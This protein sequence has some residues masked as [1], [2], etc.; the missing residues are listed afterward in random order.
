MEYQNAQEDTWLAD[1]ANI[2]ASLL[3]LGSYIAIT[4][5]IEEFISTSRYIVAAPKGYGKTLLIKYKRIKNREFARDGE[6]VEIPSNSEIDYLD[7]SISFDFKFQDFLS[8]QSEWENLWQ[9]AIGL[10]IIINYAIKRKDIEFIEEFNES[11]CADNRLT[12]LTTLSKKVAK[13]IS[14][15]QQIPIYLKTQTNPS[16]ILSMILAS[17]LSDVRS[18]ISISLDAIHNWCLAIDLPTFVYIDQIDQGVREFP[19]EI[20]KNAQNGL[21]GAAFKIHNPNSHI[22]IYASIRSE[23]WEACASEMYAQYKDHVCTLEYDQDDLK[24]IF[25]H[26]VRTYE[27]ARDSAKNEQFKTNPIQGFIGLEQVRNLWSKENEDVFQYMLRHSLQRPR[28]LILIGGGIHSLYK[29]NK[30][31]EIAFCELTNRI[32]GEEVGKQYILETLRFSKSLGEVNLQRFFSFVNKNVFSIEELVGI[33]A[34]YNSGI[35]CAAR[36]QPN[37]HLHACAG[38]KAANHIF[39]DLYKIGLLGIIKKNEIQSNSPKYQHFKTPGRIGSEHLPSSQYYILHPA[40]DYYI[41]EVLSNNL[42]SP[43]RGIIAGHRKEWKPQYDSL[44]LISRVDQL[45]KLSGINQ[46]HPTQKAIENLVNAFLDERPELATHNSKSSTLEKLK[47]Q[48]S[49]DG[50]IQASKFI[51]EILGAINTIQGVIKI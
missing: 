26:A 27:K 2:D 3:I 21:V 1:A 28:D 19:L 24:Q 31:N 23:A 43:V 39:C 44:I 30:L 15:K 18:S 46:N 41:K 48:I 25:E 36:N 42:F 37:N 5:K 8:K 17:S 45:L 50:L 51:N 22:K 11:F 16:A 12:N 38:C 40:M 49:S 35:E 29:S 32:P 33:C 9:I 20:W 7:N 47:E 6:I 13:K 4:P 34:R 10:S 14:E